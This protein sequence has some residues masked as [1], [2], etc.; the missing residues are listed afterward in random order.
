MFLT[1]PAWSQQQSQDL[2]TRS[3]EDL[4]NMKVTSVS[5]TEQTLS[6]TAAAVFVISQVDIAQSGATNIPDLLRAVPGM[7]VSEING[8]T[9]AISARGL[10]GRFSNEL[11]VLVDGRPVYTQTSGGVYWDTV[12]LPLEDIERIEVIRG[13][14]GSIWGANAVNGVVNIITKSTS[15]THGGLVVVGGGNVDQGFGTV[16]YGGKSGKN[17]DYRIYGK[18]LNQ[19]H[20][21]DSAGQDGG[22]GWHMLRGG[23]RTD[24]VLSSKDNLMLQGDIY[25]AREGV[26]TINFPSVAATALQNAEQLANLSGGFLEGAWDHAFSPHSDTTMRVSYDRY[27]RNDILQENRSTLDFDFQHHFSGWTRQDVVWGLSYQY[28]PSNSVGNLTASFVPTGFTTQLFSSFVEDEIAVIPNRF[29]LTVGTKLAHNSYTGFDLMPSVRVALT[30]GSHRTL[31]AAVSKVD[32]TPSELDTSARS[33]LSGFSG[34][35]GIPSLVTFIGNPLVKNER[36]IAYEMGYRTVVLNQL[37]IDFTTYYNS[38]GNQET[39]EP[40]TP[41]LENTPA[42]AHVIV[43]ITFEN[44]MHGTAYGLEVSVNWQP[45]TR[46]TLSPGYA[47][48]QIHMHLAPT[49]QDTTSVSDDE[50]NSPGNSAQLRSHLLVGHGLIWDT[51]AYFVGPLTD[52]SEPSYTRLDTQLSWRF[53][54]R[55]SLSFVG[56]NLLKDHHEEFVDSTGSARTTEVKRSAYVKLTWHF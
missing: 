49:S 35:G 25:T 13:P 44:L 41:F 28:S 24:S 42:P 30:F 23:F 55:A 47:F 11:L 43:P 2:T 39:S 32:R 45:N 36:L 17:T 3:I 18:Y 38:Y 26:P 54:E 46:W 20:L 40:S 22:D 48:E 52:P 34:P 16:Q 27:E 31:W 7:S 4:M 1:V 19:D 14:G 33:T 21:P 53:S 56:Q 8:N 15:D 6:H 5:K 12:D 37:S 50:G 10:N 51:S 9:W 29:F